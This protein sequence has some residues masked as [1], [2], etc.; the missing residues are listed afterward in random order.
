MSTAFERVLLVVEDSDEDFDTVLEA[1]RDCGIA[2]RV[3]RAVDGDDCLHQLQSLDAGPVRAATVV[4][5]DLGMPGLDGRGALRAMRA[6]PALRSHPVVVV[7]G[8][9]NPRDVQYCYEHGVNAYHV[10]PHRY[11]EYR[12]LMREVIGY[13]MQSVR[14]PDTGAAP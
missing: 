8:S 3:R 1:A 11:P 10:K 12:A 9:G 5:M 14:L 6:D 7:S 4:L 2:A 13:W